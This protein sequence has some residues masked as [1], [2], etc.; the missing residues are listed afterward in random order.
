[1]FLHALGT[2]NGGVLPLTDR[3]RALVVVP[4][5]HV[6]AWGLP[7]AA[8]MNGA[9]LVMPARF[10]QWGPLA[11]VIEATRPTVSSGVPSIWN[12][13][14]NY[15]DSHPEADVSS[16]HTLT[17]GGSAVPTFL[18][19]AY[20]RR[21]I[22]LL[23]GWGMTE[24][25]PV[26][27]ISQ[28]PRG[29][30]AD[31]VAW[32]SLAGRVVPGVELRIVTAEGQEAP[33][34][35]ETVG[36]IEVRGPWV[37]GSYFQDPAPEKFHDGWLC[38]GDVGHIDDYGFV[39][40]TDR[41]KDVIK[42]GGEWISSVE[43]ENTLMAHPDVREA[44]VVGVPDDRWGER[45]LAVVVRKPGAELSAEELRTWVAE[46]V[47]RWW[48]PERWSF[49]DEVP[50]TSVGKFDKKLLRQRYAQAELPVEVT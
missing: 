8:W 44:S 11:A 5:F 17:A 19:E 48:I 38:T 37:T 34:D 45:P 33:W 15:L 29:A 25:S 49:V 46:R 6:N 22:R 13:L 30:A 42:S 14:L 4:M 26:C 16:L 39:T 2:L 23:Q 21:G 31:D 12:D 27:T 18:I 47:A 32:R 43:L 7:Y 28:P 3:D 36:E 10:L 9:D 35:G 40:I 50:K 41:V 24:T 20:D 1:M